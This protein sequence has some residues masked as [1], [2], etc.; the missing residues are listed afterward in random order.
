MT[1]IVNDFQRLTYSKQIEG[2]GGRGETG[3]RCGFKNSDTSALT[4]F[5]EGD[6]RRV[7]FP[8]GCGGR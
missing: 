8:K 1:S 5:E 4:M 7:I 6:H 2:R 3:G